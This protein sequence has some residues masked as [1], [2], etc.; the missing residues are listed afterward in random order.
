MELSALQL[1]QGTRWN[2]LALASLVLAAL[3]TT[4]SILTGIWA[5]AVLAVVAGHVSLGEIWLKEERG[6]WLAI[7]ALLTGYGLAVAALISMVFFTE[8]VE[9]FAQLLG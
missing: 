9:L 7:V 1:R 6:R 2:R 3:A 5:L 4:I 8:K